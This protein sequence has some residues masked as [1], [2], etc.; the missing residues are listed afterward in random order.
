MFALVDEVTTLDDAMID[1]LGGFPL[2]V[3]PEHGFDSA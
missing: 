3:K 1:E 2:F